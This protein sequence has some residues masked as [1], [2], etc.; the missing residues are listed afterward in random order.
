[1]SYHT[2]KPY[3]TIIPYHTIP[4][5]HSKPVTRCLGSFFQDIKIISA[6]CNTGPLGSIFCGPSSSHFFWHCKLQVK[7]I[8]WT[9]SF[10]NQLDWA[11][12]QVLAIHTLHSRLQ[13]WF[14]GPHLLWT[15]SSHFF[16]YFKL[17]VKAICWTQSFEN[18]FD[19]AVSCVLAI[20]TLYMG[21]QWLRWHH[22]LSGLSPQGLKFKPP[23]VENNLDTMCIQ[24]P[25]EMPRQV[26]CMGRWRGLLF[27]PWS[28]IWCTHAPQSQW[29]HGHV[30]P[31]TLKNEDTAK[32]AD[33]KVWD[34]L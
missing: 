4:Y 6:G 12:S 25:Q 30:T 3:H 20:Y 32:E 17:Q 13:C 19:W 11:L 18:Q 34:G 10:E 28:W 22:H 14:I 16:W 26:R 27:R 1:M 15:G 5:H 23:H 21:P 7:A 29:Y 9:S 8:G 24:R 31:L 2:I 33:W